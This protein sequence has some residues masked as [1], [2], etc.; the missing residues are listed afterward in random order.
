MVKPQDLISSNEKLSQILK[1]DGIEELNLTSIGNSIS[2][3]YSWM[4]ITKPLLYRD[5]Q[6]ESLM[7]EY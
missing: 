5:E 4:N 3:G 6:I 7:A 2:S 1:N